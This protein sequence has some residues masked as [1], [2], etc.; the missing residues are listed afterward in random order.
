VDEDSLYVSDCG[1]DRVQ[2]ID[3]VTGQFQR[4]W[5]SPYPLFCD[6]HAD[7]YSPR[8][9]VFSFPGPLLLYDGIIYVGDVRSIQS[10]TRLGLFIQRIGTR[11]GH[12]KFSFVGGLVIVK[13][14]L[15]AIDVNSSR[16]QIFRSLDMENIF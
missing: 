11:E 8:A 7:N 13:D 1:N 16:V 14:K 9:G 6:P 15:Y 5:G 10:F 12:D 3:K 2:V 4:K